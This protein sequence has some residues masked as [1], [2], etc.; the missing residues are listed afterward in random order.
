MRALGFT[1]YKTPGTPKPV[2]PKAQSHEARHT[3][4]PCTLQLHSGGRPNGPSVA[5][6]LL[7][8]FNYS[9]S[10][11]AAVSRDD[12][13]GD[14][15]NDDDDDDD[16]DDDDDDDHDHDHDHDDDDDDDDD[17][18]HIVPGKLHDHPKL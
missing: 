12:D 2:W 17:V 5:V 7:L 8:T 1:R 10:L 3:C 13:D 16:E 15:G 18:S 11:R 4:V 9:K 14:D 6:E